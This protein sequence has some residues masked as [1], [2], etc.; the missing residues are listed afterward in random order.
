MDEGQTL[1]S[2]KAISSYLGRD[3]RTCQRWERELGLPI[4]RL[5]ASPAARV[6]A[7]KDEIDRWLLD[8]RREHEREFPSSARSSARPKRKRLVRPIPIVLITLSSL[9][10]ALPVWRTIVPP[11]P[12]PLPASYVQPV[13]AVVPFENKSGDGSLGYLSAALPELLVVD[14][15]QSKYLRVVSS[16]EMLTALRRL[17][18]DGAHSFSSDDIARIA[19]AT[20]AAH[21]LT[22]SF[23][24][25]GAT[26]VVM[27]DLREAAALDSSSA[28]LEFTA[29][30]EADVIPKAD[31][32][33][34]QVKKALSLTRSQIVYDFATEASQAVTASPAALKHYV[35]GRRHQ[36]SNRWD[37]AVSSMEQAIAIDPGFA[38]A[39]RTLATAHRDLQHFAEARAAIAKALEYSDRL[40]AGERELIEGQIAFWADDH[41]KAIEILERL[42]KTHRN[43]FNAMTY[44]G[45]A[46]SGAG[47]IDK[48]IEYQSRVTRSRNTV[49]DVRTLTGYLHRKGR[50]QEAADLLQA[51]LHD[52]E[53]AWGV[54]EMLAYSYAYQRKF[55]AALAE[56]RK[57]YEANPRRA[58]TPHEI[59]VFMGDLDEAE[60]LL[61]PDAMHLDR[62]R[63]AANIDHAR[64]D[65]DRARA[66]GQIEG[67][68][69]ANARLAAALEKAGRYGEAT[70]AFDEYLRL[71]AE[72][73]RLAG[74]L[75][76]RPYFRTR[77]LFFRA[78]LQAGMGSTAE[79]QK[80]AEEL[81][82]LVESGINRQDLKYYEYIIGAIKIG[83]GDPGGAVPL[84]AAAC[85]R[86]DFEDYWTSE[87]ALFLDQYARALRES[88]DLDKA[89]EIYA[90]ITLLTTGRRDDGDI[91]ARAYY[92]L[93]KSA[94]E[95]GEGRAA[96][97]NY[98]K[99]LA[100][101][102]RAD[103]GLPE[104]DDARARLGRF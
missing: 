45:Y 36:M 88:G 97:G 76:Y 63:F 10:I 15:L 46:Y 82:A 22:G 83:E 70:A 104:V 68:A 99:F 39:Y 94:E 53:D 11:K 42:L 78:R 29:H 7:Y 37:E 98:R 9:A 84:L 30:D 54:R 49:V 81:Q 85:G 50:Y 5:D 44:L 21:V 67:E 32:L 19:S 43:H 3:I 103:P 73:R 89:Q 27:A 18:L 33:A 74:D 34:R 4:H 65:L 72:S 41:A 24:K 23:V 80:T 40:P 58:A 57:T 56:A 20:R 71:S 64:R 93:G 1:E 79:A 8:K 25:A 61:G 35:E 52:V 6:L 86:L 48:A 60:Y 31:K 26:I 38:M 12:P 102:D 100:L 28:R 16:A 77:D 62:G 66:D 90:K 92:W 47:D 96:R 75:P 91:Y 13:V 59:L 101:W 2:W 51:F 17:G 87:Q 69:A 55:D 95:K 14:L